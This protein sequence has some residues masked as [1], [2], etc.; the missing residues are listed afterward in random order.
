VTYKGVV[1]GRTIELE[2]E[3]AL[4]AGTRVTVDLF[5]EG[6]ARKGSPQAILQLVGTLT[7][8][9]GELIRAGAKLARKIDPSLWE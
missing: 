9:E 8:Q 7:P 2:S 6:A 1:R 3:P 4:P 5:A